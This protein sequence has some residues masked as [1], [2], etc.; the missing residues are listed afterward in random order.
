MCLRSRSTPVV[1]VIVAPVPQ[2]IREI[3]E[4]IQCEPQE[5]TPDAEQIADMPVPQ[6]KVKI[7]GVPSASAKFGATL[8]SHEIVDGQ[9]QRG[10]H[11]PSITE[12]TG[13]AVHGKERL[14]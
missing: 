14:P 13:T 10:E 7:V 6:L 4:A 2:I 9:Q 1:E 5:G 8:A 12:V 11:V 3:A